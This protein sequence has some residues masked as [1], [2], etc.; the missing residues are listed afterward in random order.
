MFAYITPERFMKVLAKESFGEDLH[1]AQFPK[2]NDN[3]RYLNGF[4]PV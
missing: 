3:G 2:L 1:F 4:S